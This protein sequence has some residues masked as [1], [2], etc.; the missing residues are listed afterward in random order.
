M[1]SVLRMISDQLTEFLDEMVV[2]G[3]KPDVISYNNMILAGLFN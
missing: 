2:K 1:G 3:L